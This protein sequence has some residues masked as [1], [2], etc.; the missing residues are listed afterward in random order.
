MRN[1]YMGVRVYMT[2]STKMLLCIEYREFGEI[3][4]A[5]RV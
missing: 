4:P 3:I 1:V 5:D 2:L